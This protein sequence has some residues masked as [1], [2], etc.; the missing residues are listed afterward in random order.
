MKKIVKKKTK[1]YNVSTV[2]YISCNKRAE[3]KRKRSRQNKNSIDIK[4]GGTE[5]DK[6]KERKERRDKLT[7]GKAFEE[8]LNF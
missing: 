5:N 1:N 4:T 3:E 6:R 8:V 2:V 7:D